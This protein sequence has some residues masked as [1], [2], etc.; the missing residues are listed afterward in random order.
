MGKS[1]LL[2]IKADLEAAFEAAERNLDF[3]KA[4]RVMASAVGA[5]QKMF[6][7]LKSHVE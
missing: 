3:F 7:E 2:G 1:D 6:S 5:R 4:N